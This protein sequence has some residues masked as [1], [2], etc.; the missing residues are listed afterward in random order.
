MTVRTILYA[1]GFDFSGRPRTDRAKDR[2]IGLKA[3]TEI[4]PTISNES[5]LV[6]PA[7]AQKQLDAELVPQEKAIASRNSGKT[8]GTVREA[9]AKIYPSSS[10]CAAR[11][12]RDQSLKEQGVGATP[13]LRRFYGNIEIDAVRVNRDF[14][15]DRQ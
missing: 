2:Y 14:P 5:L 13:V 6:K 15:R 12:L 4:D 11:T 9:K 7:L 3:G 1:E 8:T 10:D